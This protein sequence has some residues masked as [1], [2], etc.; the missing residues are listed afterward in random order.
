MHRI[1]AFLVHGGMMSHTHGLS[2]SPTTRKGNKWVNEQ[3]LW[4]C[5]VT[6]AMVVY[7]VARSSIR[8]CPCQWFRVHVLC[9]LQ[10]SRCCE[11]DWPKKARF[12][13]THLTSP[14]LQSLTILAG[15]RRRLAM[16]GGQTRSPLSGWLCSQYTLGVYPVWPPRR[17]GRRRAHRVAIEDSHG[18][19]P[20]V[21]K[22]ASMNESATSS[23]PLRRHCAS[24]PNDQRVINL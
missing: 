22:R 3:V 21:D 1:L 7:L 20:V 10:H 5:S 11:F 6:V 14:V 16:V 18:A 12:A 9:N 15:V 2:L 24:A 17:R 19:P 8:E 13:S 4:S 23:S